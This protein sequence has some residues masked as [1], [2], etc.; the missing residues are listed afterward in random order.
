MAKGKR[1]RGSAKHPKQAHHPR[2]SKTPASDPS[3]VSLQRE[4]IVW[5]F[6]VFDNTPWIDGH[7]P[8][9]RFCDI[10]QS[11]KGYESRTWAEVDRSHT[12]DHPVAIKGLCPTAQRRLHAL[13]M[14]DI[15]QLWRFRFSNRQRL[16]GIRDRQYFK[17]L[18]WDPEHKVCPSKKK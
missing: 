8:G 7:A 14:D 18:W 11:M 13:K 16:W 4:Q 12:R 2:V 9:D 17:V 6:L 3:I 5:S 15:D 1:N 10:A